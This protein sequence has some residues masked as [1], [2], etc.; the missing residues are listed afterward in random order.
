MIELSKDVRKAVEMLVTCLHASEA[1]KDEVTVLAAD[2][3]CRRLTNEI[4]GKR[5]SD[6]DIKANVKLG[7]LVTAG[8]F[9]QI[10]ATYDSAILKPYK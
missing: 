10:D 8:K 6:D 5:R 1:G 3:L 4:T 2:V 9:T 7:K